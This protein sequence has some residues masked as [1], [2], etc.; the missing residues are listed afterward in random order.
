MSTDFWLESTGYWAEN[1]PGLRCRNDGQHALGVW[2]CLAT[3]AAA[4]TVAAL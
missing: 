4:S 1:S 2:K 3:G